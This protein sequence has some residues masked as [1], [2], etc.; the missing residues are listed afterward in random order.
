[1]IELKK[2][3]VHSYII[4]SEESKRCR[5]QVVLTDNRSHVLET[6]YLLKRR[7]YRWE[8]EPF[9]FT[10]RKPNDQIIIKTTTQKLVLPKISAS[11]LISS[12]Y[13]DLTVKR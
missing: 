7:K 1:M 5:V 12:P 6:Y 4:N 3:C 13:F 10:M 9:S 8:N 2:I 11:Q